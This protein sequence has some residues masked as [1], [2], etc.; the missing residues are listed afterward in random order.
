YNHDNQ[1]LSMVTLARE[2][3]ELIPP[4]TLDRKALM[5]LAR[6]TVTYADIESEV[7]P[8][9][10]VES[11]AHYKLK[12]EDIALAIKRI[13]STDNCL[14]EFRKWYWVIIN[15]FYENY[16]IE[17]RRTKEDLSDEPASEDELFSTV[18]ELTDQ[19]YWK[20]E[21]RFG[22]REEH[23]KHTVKF[24]DPFNWRPDHIT[25]REIEEAA[26]KAVC[27]DIISRVDTYKQNLSLEP[28][29]RQYSVSMKRHF[30][31]SVKDNKELAA[32]SPDRLLQFK[33]FV[34]D[35]AKQGDVKALE[36]L[37]WSYYEG[38][39]AYTQSWPMAEK[40]LLKLFKQTGDPNAANGLG[41]I[42]FY[43]WTN[44]N[45]PLCDKA[46]KYFSYGSLAGVPESDYKTS[47]LMIYGMGTPKNV[48][49]GL[50]ILIDGYKHAYTEFCEGHYDNKFADFALRM[51]HACKNNLIYGLGMRDAYKFYLEA[52]YAI[53]ARR[54]LSHQ[55]GDDVV[56]GKIAA[57]LKELQES[58]HIDIN[59]QTVA[60]DFP[61]YINLLYEDRFPVK[62][63]IEVDKKTH[64][65]VLKICRSNIGEELISKGIIPKEYEGIL[66]IVH[67]PRMLITHP[68]LSF[69][70]LTDRLEY[71]LVNV[72]VAQ[73]PEAEG[74]FLSDGFR[75]NDMT[76]ALEFYLQGEM[77]A[78]VECQWY[79]VR[80]PD[81]FHLP[82]KLDY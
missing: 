79:V 65:G 55:Y 48:D 41:Y 50:D 31:G 42:Y 19:L 46:F 2:V 49:L 71:E 40:Y 16:R 78:T 23:Q 17:E 67:S 74:P 36:I 3:L 51:G 25:G 75:R 18:Y 70:D 53:K 22:R 73:K 82:E 63:D 34:N 64:M 44:H 14:E 33:K 12:A 69:S 80:R 4:R 28:W 76:Q 24:R 68:E 6:R 10:N 58:L 9:F 32:L 43:G 5:Q 72:S 59:T 45:E 56:E 62:I 39:P 1:P 81:H 52:M 15:L 57:A 21:E 54:K 47:D 26:Y 37:A 27:E 35:L 7:F 61:I 30:I 77:V 13:N 20:L 29:Q 60:A 11:S 8:P 38:S 66:K